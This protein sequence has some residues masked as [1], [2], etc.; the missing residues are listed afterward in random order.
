MD[1]GR[2]ELHLVGGYQ[3]RENDHFP[4]ADQVVL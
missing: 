2:F 3:A 1:V 4:K